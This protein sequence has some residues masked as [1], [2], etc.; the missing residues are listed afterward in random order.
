MDPFWKIDKYLTSD[1]NFRGHVPDTKITMSVLGLNLPILAYAKTAF[2]GLTHDP[3]GRRLKL[4]PHLPFLT[5][6][7]VEGTP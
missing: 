6:L 2:D 3:K 7:A 4:I 5:K 1:L